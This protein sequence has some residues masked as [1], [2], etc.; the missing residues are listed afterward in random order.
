M[1]HPCSY[2]T[3]LI[4]IH[5]WHDSFM[6]ETPAVL[7]TKRP[8][9]QLSVTWLIHI[10][11]WYY[12]FVCDTTRL[13]HMWGIHICE[14]DSIICHIWSVLQ[15]VAEYC[16][17]L[18]C[19]QC[20]LTLTL[21]YVIF[22]VCC[23][24]LQWIAVCC[25][26]LQ[27]VLTLTHLYV[28]FAVCC[29]VLQCVA[30]CCSVLQCVAV[31]WHWLIHM[32][33]LE[34]FGVCCSVLQCVAVCC[35]VLQ[36]V[37]MCRHWLIYVWYDSLWHI[38]STAT[39]CN[40]LQHTATHCNTLQHTATHYLP[41]HPRVP[42]H[43]QTA[44]CSNLPANTPTRRDRAWCL[45]RTRPHTWYKYDA[46]IGDMT[47]YVTWSICDM[48]PWPCIEHLANS[49]SYLIYARC[50]HGL[51]YMWHDSYVTW[52]L[53]DMTPWPC[54]EPLTNSP[55]YIHDAFICDM[56]HYVAWLI[57][58]HDSMTVSPTNSLSNL[59]CIWH[60]HMLEMTHMWHDSCVAMTHMWHDSYV[61]WLRDHAWCLSRTRP[62]THS[63]HVCKLTRSWPGVLRPRVYTPLL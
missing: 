30:V 55:S 44:P 54:I 40:T 17:V 60:I 52:V 32:W 43:F 2:V 20:V 18:Q 42:H 38:G 57:C 56:T 48:T 29:S 24:V 16:S 50:F 62:H 12:L 53:C 19:V 51:I 22:G 27:C 63:I 45:S 33:Y 31:C 59:I 47:D 1:T 9:V 34:C 49:P 21:L 26:V 61:T 39:H 36:F 28:I 13:I 6:F 58:W 15:R 35:S 5:M 11:M 3:W 10:H 37:A 46:F 23:S 7:H 4:H 14:I 41:A 8:Y 25:T